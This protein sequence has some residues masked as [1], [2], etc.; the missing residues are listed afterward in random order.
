MAGGGIG[1]DYTLRNL[2]RMLPGLLLCLLFGWLALQWD[3]TVHNWEKEYK[4]AGVGLNALK[5]GKATA[6]F[7]AYK[8][9]KDDTYKA[10]LGQFEKRTGKEKALQTLCLEESTYESVVT[11]GTI[12]TRLKFGNLMIQIQM[13][14]VAVLL[15]LGMLIRNTIGLAASSRP[16]PSP[17]GP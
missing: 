6:D 2:P 10:A 1:V 9:A 5:D 16:A 3:A 14:Y 4:E 11:S 12:P 13:T 17:P 8:Q 15:L 7:S